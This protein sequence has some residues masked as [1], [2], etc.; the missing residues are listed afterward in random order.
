MSNTIAYGQYKYIK[1][2][3]SCTSQP[4]EGKWSALR[5]SCLIHG[6]T[7]RDVRGLGGTQG[8]SKEIFILR[9][10]PFG[11]TALVLI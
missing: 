2:P 7:V 4:D 10:N 6:K 1:L 9:S 5:S 8:W 3:A 11:N